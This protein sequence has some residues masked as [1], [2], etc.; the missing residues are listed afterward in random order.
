MDIKQT[1]ENEP[2]TISVHGRLEYQGFIFQVKNS[3]NQT[4]GEFINFDEDVYSPVV[5]EEEQEHSIDWAG[6]I[7][8]V[9]AKLKGWPIQ[10]SWTSA[11]Q[12]VYDSMSNVFRV[13]GM[14]VVSK[15]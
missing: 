15:L 13:Q 14:V 6:S 7:G 9:D 10:L 3:N 5:C 11:R 4:V 1:T 8:H 12:D 2:F